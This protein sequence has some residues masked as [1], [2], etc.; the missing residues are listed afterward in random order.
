[1]L[2]N[3]KSLLVLLNKQNENQEL[4]I[5]ND[6]I[7]IEKGSAR[8]SYKTK[9]F[10]IAYKENE[11]LSLSMLASREDLDSFAND[12][13]KPSLLNQDP[14]FYYEVGENELF[15]SKIR[16]YEWSFSKSN[17]R[18]DNLQNQKE[19]DKTLALT[20]VKDLRELPKI[21]AKR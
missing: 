12:F 13:I 10:G 8:G 5:Y 21:K 19:I 4:E 18:L 3:I 7:D 17:E 1:M 16:N 11:Y 9:H 6:S 15:G 14:S 20:N 2:N